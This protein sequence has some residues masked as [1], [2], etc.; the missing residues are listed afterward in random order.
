[1]ARLDFGTARRTVVTGMAFALAAGLPPPATAQ[2]RP[3]NANPYGCACLHNNTNQNIN[4]RYHWGDKQW[5]NVALKANHQ[6]WLCWTYAQGTASSPPL[7]FQIDVDL[8]KANAWTTYSIERV[9][10][11][12]QDCSAIGRKG[13]YDIGFR[14]NTNNAFIHITRRQ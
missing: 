11:R 1:M 10:S 4:Y 5:K 8:S 2:N 3:Q 14:P 6:Q 13:H 7:Q 9:Q 12:A